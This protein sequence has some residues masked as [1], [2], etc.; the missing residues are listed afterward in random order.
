M[1]GFNA[2]DELRPILLFEANYG[3]RAPTARIGLV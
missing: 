3:W 2:E 1:N